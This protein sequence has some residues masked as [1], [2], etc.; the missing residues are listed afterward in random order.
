MHTTCYE[1]NY[2][3]WV[4]ANAALEESPAK[5]TKK[6]WNKKSNQNMEW[7][8]ILFDPLGTWSEVKSRQNI[9]LLSEEKRI[10]HERSGKIPS[11][12]KLE[13]ERVENRLNQQKREQ[14]KINELDCEVA[15]TWTSDKF[16]DKHPSS[17]S[18]GVKTHITTIVLLGPKFT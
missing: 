11:I 13:K 9:S 18:F 6:E 1:Q 15:I 16:K 8:D 10:E 5:C 4:R 3:C 14:V 17:F 2:M 12:I 7:I